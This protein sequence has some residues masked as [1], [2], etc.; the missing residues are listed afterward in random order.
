MKAELPETK[1]GLLEAAQTLL[2]RQGFAATTVDQIC[3]AAGLTKGSFF[4]YFKS[5]D[6]LGEAVVEYFYA[7]Q[8]EQFARAGFLRLTDPLARLHGLLDFT[9]Q[10]VT[11]DEKTQSCLLGNLSQEL[12]HTHP[13]I[14]RKCEACFAGL[15]GAV[16][17]TLRQAKKQYRPKVDFD[18]ESVATLF[19]SLF[20]GSRILAKARQDARPIVEGLGH[21]RAYVEQLF[22]R[23]RRNRK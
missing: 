7:Q 22:G 13:R 18:P 6:A 2:L 12:S 10:S 11:G 15:S 5:K 3:A 9:A 17:E 20:Q 4:H 8:R 14:R 23:T 21:F 19:L 16:A 1:A